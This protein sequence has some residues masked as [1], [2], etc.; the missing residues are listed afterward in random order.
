MG[1]APELQGWLHTQLCAPTAAGMA[2]DS[3][4][5]TARRLLAARTLAYPYSDDEAVALLS[6]SIH[7]TYRSPHLTHRKTCSTRHRQN[8]LSRQASKWSPPC[9][10]WLIHSGHVAM[11]A[12]H[13]YCQGFLRFKHTGLLQMAQHT[14]PD[15]SVGRKHTGPAQEALERCDATHRSKVTP[16]SLYR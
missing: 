11:P 10:Q 8:A 13:L 16:T 6:V 1:Q 7:H 5:Y 15:P 12:P 14:R 3:T 2:S 4:R 9:C